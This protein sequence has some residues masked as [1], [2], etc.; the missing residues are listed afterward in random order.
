MIRPLRVRHRVT[1]LTLV[2]VLPPLFVAALLGREPTPAAGP[3]SAGLEVAFTKAPRCGEP[4][5]ID[6]GLWGELGITTRV[7]VT[8]GAPFCELEARS[9]LE[10]PDLLL[11]WTA[12]EQPDTVPDD[13][14]LLGGWRAGR[15]CFALPQAASA[16]ADDAGQLM[17]YS[18]AH[19]RVVGT[20]SLTRKGG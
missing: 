15:R 18:L 11:Y 4:D 3:L 16:E 2:V 6:E 8:D 5:W 13:A 14:V 19:S 7:G 10:L 12:A 17:L 9:E 1:A 20:A